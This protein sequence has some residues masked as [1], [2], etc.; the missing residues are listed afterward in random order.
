MFENYVVEKY[1]KLPNWA[2]A[3]LIVSIVLH[4]G[5]GAGHQ[6]GQLQHGLAVRVE[7]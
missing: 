2:K 1:A 7:P 5:G 6:V 4:A 3:L